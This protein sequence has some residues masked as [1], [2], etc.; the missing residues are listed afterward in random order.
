MINLNM[1]RC[2]TEID[3]SLIDRIS[4]LISIRPFFVDY[5]HK[6]KL[7]ESGIQGLNE[8]FTMDMTQRAPTIT[9]KC[10][11]NGLLM[12]L[13]CRWVNHIILWLIHFRIPIANFTTQSPDYRKR[14]LHPEY[15]QIEFDDIYV[16]I[17]KLSLSDISLYWTIYLKSKTAK[18][19]Y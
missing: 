2:K 16:E 14:N 17:P 18:G 19:N 9:V 1:E 10:K 13:R 12:D 6:L 8:N 15:L 4:N 3:L 11:C 5:K 7:S